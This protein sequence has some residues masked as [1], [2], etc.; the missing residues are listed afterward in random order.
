MVLMLDSFPHIAA[1]M[2]ATCRALLP[3]CFLRSRFASAMEK[4]LP[5]GYIGGRI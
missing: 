3:H 1:L 5:G 2:R 4:S